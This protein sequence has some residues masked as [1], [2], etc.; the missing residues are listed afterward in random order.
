MTYKFSLLLLPLLIVVQSCSDDRDTDET[1]HLDLKNVKNRI[2][3]LGASRVEGARPEFESY[4]YELWKLLV[5]ND[6]EFDFI[7]TMKDDAPYPTYNDAIFDMDH[8]GRG[9]WTSGQILNGID[10][11]LALAGAPDIVLF[12]SPGGNDALN[13]DPYG[14]AISNINEIIDAIQ[15]ANS[16][17]TIIIEQLAPAKSEVMTA[18]LTAFFNQLQQDVVVIASQQSTPNS[19]VLTV[20]M[21]TGFNDS[22]LT[23]DVHYNETGAKFIAARYFDLLQN[24]LD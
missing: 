20:D 21:V 10:D 8:E 5:D 18:Q 19:R 24:E 13:G 23:D 9:G 7:G 1:A 3:P 16:E 4:R 17:V 14:Q 2:M 11:W 12:S 15:S 22:L 6:V